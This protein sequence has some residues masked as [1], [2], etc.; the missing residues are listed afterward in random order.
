MTDILIIILLVIAVVILVLQIVLKPKD[1]TEII[2]RKNRK[3]EEDLINSNKQLN[4]YLGQR[5]EDFNTS[6]SDKQELIRRS[7]VESI[8]QQEERFKTFSEENARQLSEIRT[9]VKDSLTSI[10]NDNNKRLEEMR[11]IVDEKLQR[12]IESKMNESFK[13]V[14]ERLEQVYQGLG[15]MKN[16]AKGVGDLKKVLSNVKT[17]GILGEVQLGAILR[18]I[19]APE[20]YEENVAVK[21][22]SREVVEFAIKLPGDEDS[23]V[24]LPIDSKFPGDTYQA[25]TE[26]YESGDKIRIDEC[27]KALIRVVTAEAKDISAKYIDPPNTTNFAI[28]FLPFEGLYAEVVNRG[29]LEELQ[30]KYNVNIAGPSTMAALLNSLQM[31]FNTLAIRKRSVEI[32]KVLQA[33]K[34]EFDRFEDVLKATQNKLS[35]ANDDLDKLIGT[36]TRMIR[37]KLKSVSK[38]EDTEEASRLLGVDDIEE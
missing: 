33:V 23:Y 37:S 2:D 31:G 6:I 34:T 12:S 28:M 24:Y 13:L 15:E 4:Q 5:I 1:I 26:A 19:L 27:A 35:K 9:S 7:F 20:Q 29:L 8:S 22:D 14:S 36:R 17:R 30:R 16:L 3:L 10:Q 18:E 21:P 25:L 11:V 32:E 38:L